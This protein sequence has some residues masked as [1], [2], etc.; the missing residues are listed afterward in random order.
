VRPLL[1]LIALLAVAGFVGG[2]RAQDDG[3]AAAEASAADCVTTALAFDLLQVV[4]RNPLGIGPAGAC[5]AGFGA[6]ALVARMPEP[7]RTGSLHALS[8][9][10]WGA[11]ANNLA[12]LLGVTGPAAPALG[13]A[14]AIAVWAEGAPEREF[15]EQC[16][17]HE[18]LAGH[19]MRCDYVPSRPR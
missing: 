19:P 4:E 7:A 10:K 18:R 12:V 16:A 1:H 6:V 8:A 15:K 17:V 13:A 3:K 5:A 2:A 11:A 9:V 14:V